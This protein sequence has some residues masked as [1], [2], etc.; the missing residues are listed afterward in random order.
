MHERRESQEKKSYSFHQ[1]TN[2]GAGHTPWSNLLQELSMRNGYCLNKLT[3]AFGDRK[4]SFSKEDS[5]A[6]QRCILLGVLELL[7]AIRAVESGL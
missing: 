3:G 2:W 6:S 5:I 4:A 1:A 7:R